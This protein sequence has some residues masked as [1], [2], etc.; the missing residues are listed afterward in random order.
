[1]LRRIFLQSAKKLLKQNRTR[2]M[3]VN[4]LRKP[5]ISNFSEQIQEE[6]H[7]EIDI[8]GKKFD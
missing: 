1:M 5:L 2:I 3:K 7:E 4:S 6:I 8:K